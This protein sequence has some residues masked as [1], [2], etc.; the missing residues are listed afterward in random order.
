[1]FRG[2]CTVEYVHISLLRH[3]I[4]KIFVDDT[5]ASSGT[6]VIGVVTVTARA[7]TPAMT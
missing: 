1:M 2:N 7:A 5:A 4:N 3:E 6:G